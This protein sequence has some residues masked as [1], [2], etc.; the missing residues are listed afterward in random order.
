MRNIVVHYHIF[1][2]AGSSVDKILEMSFCDRWAT[3]EGATATSLLNSRDLCLFVRDH[4]DLCAVSSHLLRPPTPPELH[5]LPIVLVRHPLDRAYS[6]YSQLRRNGGVLPGEQAARRASFAGF[7]RW[8]LD[9]KSLGGMV[10]ADYQVIHLSQASFRNEHIYNAVATESDLQQ[11]TAYLS[12]DVFFGPVEHF[13]A[14][15]EGLQL[16]AK[17]VDLSI[18]A[19]SATENVTSGRPADLA[20]RLCVIEAQLGA[21]LC[22]R[23]REANELDYRLYEWVCRYHKLESPGM[24]T[25][26]DS[27]VK[28]ITTASSCPGVR[29]PSSDLN[30]RVRTQP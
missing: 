22:D 10:I 13:D 11:A 21:A 26:T 4:P 3:F 28:D 6:V 24:T 27:L 2:N 15:M 18:V 7:V 1:K 30:R 12:N 9:Y 25:R 8:C 17:Q 19:T 23:Y 20:E 5:V 29:L 16:A 14:V